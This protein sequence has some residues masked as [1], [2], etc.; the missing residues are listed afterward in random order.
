MVDRQLEQQ[1]R[2]ITADITALGFCLPGSLITRSTRC[3]NPGCHCQSEPAQLHGPYLTW[4]RK[5]GAK[6]VT[7]N[8]SAAQ[9]E[10]YRP[11]FDNSRRLRELINE[12]ETLS[13]RAA[14]DAER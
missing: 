2:K 1:R 5:V 13:V 8:L 11:W 3:G 4:T 7:R 9:A 14:S 10:R 12:L 6:T